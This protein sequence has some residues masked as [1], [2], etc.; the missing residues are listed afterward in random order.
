MLIKCLL[1]FF[2][3]EFHQKIKILFPQKKYSEFAID[4]SVEISF[5]HWNRV[6]LFNDRAAK[7]AIRFA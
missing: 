5:F 6:I 1:F 3:I 2:L 7:I 4:I